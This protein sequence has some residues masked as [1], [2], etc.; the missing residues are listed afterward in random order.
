M[1]YTVSA[2]FFLE[3]DASKVWEAPVLGTEP[4]LFG[5]QVIWKDV[6]S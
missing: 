2:E 3:T 4:T 6:P 1:T 5:C